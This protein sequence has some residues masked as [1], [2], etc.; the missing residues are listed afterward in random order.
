MEAKIS[1]E[2]LRAMADEIV[3]RNDDER[4]LLDTV[5]EK[6]KR[7]GVSI[8]TALLRVATKTIRTISEAHTLLV[9]L[10]IPWSEK[11]DNPLNDRIRALAL[12]NNKTRTRTECVRQMF[13]EVL[14]HQERNDK[15]TV[16]SEE[17][18]RL[19]TRIDAE[20]F[21]EKIEALYDEEVLVKVLRSLMDHIGKFGAIRKDLHDRLPEFA[22]AL[23]DNA[24][25]NEGFAVLFGIDLEPVFRE[26]MKSNMA[27]KGGP[28]IDGKLN[29]PNGWEPPNVENELRK[30]GWTV[31]HELEI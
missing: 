12:P 24:V 28:I 20:E 15:P 25:T 8:S 4:K 26:V 22:D 9:E 21:V 5:K 2:I 11:A 3:V 6:S 18:I 10:G 30:Q 29:K 14:P 19:Q 7:E 23:A 13:V 16:P 27:K 17:A 1:F 31:V